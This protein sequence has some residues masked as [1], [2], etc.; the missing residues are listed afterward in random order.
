MPSAHASGDARIT[1]RGKK[2]KRRDCHPHL[3]A[4]HPAGFLENTRR[5]GRL[6]IASPG[7]GARV[8]EQPHR[9]PAPLLTKW[10]ERTYYECPRCSKK[11]FHIRYMPTSVQID[12]DDIQPAGMEC[13]YCGYSQG[14]LWLKAKCPICHGVYEYPANGYKP[15][16]CRRFECLHS[17]LH[18]ELRQ[19]Q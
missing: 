14:S 17:Y 9:Y 6:S 15:P 10:D 4:D 3:G 8:A 7:K 1:R 19:K 13:K 2:E 18:P 12:R 16:T 11:G 5:R